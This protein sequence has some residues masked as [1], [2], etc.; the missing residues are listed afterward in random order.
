MFNS[1][2]MAIEVS[3]GLGNAKTHKES[4]NT[5]TSSESL[6]S[7][8]NIVRDSEKAINNSIENFDGRKEF[9]FTDV[10]SYLIPMIRNKGN[11]VTKKVMEVFS[12][13]RVEDK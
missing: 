1:L 8:Y 13:D 11:N 12:P 2:E 9:R 5:I 7:I 4:V 10:E 3:T 6:K